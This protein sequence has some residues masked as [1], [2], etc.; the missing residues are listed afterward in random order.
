MGFKSCFALLLGSAAAAAWQQQQRVGMLGIP[1]PD[2]FGPG[3]Q[4]SPYPRMPEV[5][6]VVVAITDTVTITGLHRVIGCVVGLRRRQHRFLEGVFL[7]R[8]M[9]HRGMLSC[10]A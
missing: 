9:T 4:M 8:T 1:Y 5:V 6:L 7:R 3:H 10:K 2:N